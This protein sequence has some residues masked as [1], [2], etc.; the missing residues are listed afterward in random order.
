MATSDKQE[1]IGTGQLATRASG[2]GT[3][4]CAARRESMS[5]LVCVT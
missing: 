5:S 2:S 3:D 4:R 1:A